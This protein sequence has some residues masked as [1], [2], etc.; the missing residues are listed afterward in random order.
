[1]R[2]AIATILVLTTFGWVSASAAESAIDDPLPRRGF[3]GAQLMAVPPEW[4]E[5]LRLGPQQGAI[6]TGIIP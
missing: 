4:R 1:M 3:L 6:I 5:M 2:P